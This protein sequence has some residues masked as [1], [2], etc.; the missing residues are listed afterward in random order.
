LHDY[1]SNRAIVA[2]ILGLCISFR[3]SVHNIN[4]CDVCRMQFQT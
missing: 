4:S 3:R 2:M 1:F